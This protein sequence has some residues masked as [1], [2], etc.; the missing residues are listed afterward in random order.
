MLLVS[1]RIAPHK[2]LEHGAQD[3][4]DIQPQRPI[5]NVPQIEFGAFFE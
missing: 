1:V 2:G 5:F 3:N 4:L